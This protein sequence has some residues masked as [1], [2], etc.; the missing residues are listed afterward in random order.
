MLSPIPTGRLAPS[1][2]SS[3]YRK[4]SA[5]SIPPS[6]GSPPRAASAFAHSP[7]RSPKPLAPSDR[8]GPSTS[9]QRRRAASDLTP[10]PPSL[11]G[12]GDAGGEARS[13]AP[14]PNREGTGG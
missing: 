13:E 1:S 4:S 11:K 10:W 8:G 3:P 2:R 5:R 7:D 14:S 12:R 9:R 6:F